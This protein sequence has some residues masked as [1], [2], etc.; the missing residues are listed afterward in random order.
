MYDESTSSGTSGFSYQR[1]FIV[2]L[3]DA[4]HLSSTDTNIAGFGVDVNAYYGWGLRDYFTSSAINSKLIKIS[5]NLGNGGSNL[6]PGFEMAWDSFLSNSTRPG[7]QAWLIVLTDTTYTSSTKGLDEAKAAGVKV[8]VV[9]TGS[10]TSYSAFASDS[11]YVVSGMSWG[12]LSSYITNVVEFFCPAYCENFVFY[13]DLPNS[14]SVQ[15]DT[16]SNVGYYLSPTDITYDIHCCGAVSSVEFK[17]TT[18][19]TFKFQIWRNYV[20]VSETSVSAAA[21]FQT[22]TFSP[23]LAV[24]A[25]DVIGWYSSGVNPIGIAS[26]CS[27]DLCTSGTKRATSMG[28]VSVGSSYSW[29]NA[30]DLPDTAFAIKFTIV[31]REITL[32]AP[33]PTPHVET[34]YTLTIEVMDSCFNTA[35]ATVNITSYAVPPSFNNLPTEVELGDDVTAE[36]ILIVVNVT[37]ESA[38][39]ITCTQTS[40]LPE[41]QYFRLDDYM[42][43][44]CEDFDFYYDEPNTMNVQA[45]NFSNVGYY[46]DGLDLAYNIHCC[47]AVSSV[48]FKATTSGTFKFQIWRKEMLVSETS[49]SATGV[50]PIGIASSCYGTLCTSSTKRAQNMGTVAIGSIYSWY[51]ATILPDTAF[52]IKFTIVNVTALTFTMTSPVF[53]SETLAVGSNVT[54]VS[55]THDT[56]ME[57]MYTDPSSPYFSFDQY[58]GLIS[59]IG[60]LPV[61]NTETTYVLVIE[62][63]DTCYNSAT[64]TLNITSYSV[65]P[66]FHNLPTEVE[67]GD[68]VTEET[69]L[70]VINATD[71]SAP[72]IICTK[73]SILPETQ[74]FRLDDY[75]NGSAAVYLNADSQLDF[76]T[77]EEYKMFIT[78]TGSSSLESILTIRILDKSVT[79]PYSV[80]DW[81]AGA[82]VVSVGSMGVVLG[83]VCFLI[84]VILATTDE[85][86]A[87][88][89]VEEEESTKAEVDDTAKI[90]KNIDRKPKYREG[91]VF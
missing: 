54:E 14:M 70:I 15:A 32:I 44:Y 42:N 81:A 50:N 74:F 55:V 72:F 67:I 76:N 53:I 52:A 28:A 69:L 48:E 66:S 78:C 36:T 56:G 20:L 80:P 57:L 40:I 73:T 71:E 45:D 10:V 77:A 12:T 86:E 37:D 60:P 91:R 1:Q 35:T 87:L 85:A 31:N 11:K 51:S 39:I 62:V 24:Q 19:G 27:G 83:M 4:L 58:T 6:A 63:Y 7:S 16:H 26:N 84:V 75:M 22:H 65:P 59:L 2:S 79:T 17:A 38:P 13:Y 21:G 46:L 88:P 29:S 9:G 43:G 25:K 41:T 18:S 34:P 61:T 47:G 49:I 89:P 68:D 33:L 3:A 64:A 82:I 23:K 8:G 5:S 90:Y 30:T